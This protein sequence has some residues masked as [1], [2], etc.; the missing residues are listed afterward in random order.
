MYNDQLVFE[1]V[2]EKY[3]QISS[4][5][6]SDEKIILCIQNAFSISFELPQIS[7]DLSILFIYISLIRLIGLTFYSRVFRFERISTVLSVISLIDP[8]IVG[9]EIIFCN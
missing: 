4:Y 7:V 3:I 9:L 8:R 6:L 5:C 1:F 2:F